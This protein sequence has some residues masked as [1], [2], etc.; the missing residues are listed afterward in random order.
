MRTTI[1]AILVLACMPL[2]AIT[3]IEARTEFVR[4]QVNPALAKVLWQIESAANAG[5]RGVFVDLEGYSPDVLEPVYKALTKRG[6]Q[7]EGYVL[8][9]YLL[10]VT[11]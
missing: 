6:F 9:P 4:V 8:R 2:N 11:W 7:V 5:E 3:A 10:G 1:F